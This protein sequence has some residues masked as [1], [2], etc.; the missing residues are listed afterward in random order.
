M[1]KWKSSGCAATAAAGAP[2][3]IG[4]DCA[5]R[6]EPKSVESV[7]T[8]LL[9]TE[10]NQSVSLQAEDRRP[11]G[12]GCST[13]NFCGV[14]EGKQS[15]TIYLRKRKKVHGEYKQATT[16]KILGDPLR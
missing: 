12:L 8:G 7:G 14:E 6:L 2:N 16:Q 10:T 15:T 9:S 11:D 4:C 13:I 1:C 3:S 5:K